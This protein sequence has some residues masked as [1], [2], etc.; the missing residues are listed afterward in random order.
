M[1][2]DDKET[3]QD[4]SSVIISDVLVTI[5]TRMKTWQSEEDQRTCVRYAMALLE[6]GVSAR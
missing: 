4:R 2:G 1:Q 6:N 3:R 5:S